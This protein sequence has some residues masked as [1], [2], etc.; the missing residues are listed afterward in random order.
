[1]NGFVRLL[2]LGAA[3]FGA[4]QALRRLR[5]LADPD[6]SMYGHPS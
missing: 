4:A 5:Q 2:L 6:A 1:M 3:I